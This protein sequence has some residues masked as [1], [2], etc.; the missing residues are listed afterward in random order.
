MKRYKIFISSVQSEFREERRDLKAF[1]LQDPIIK[2]FVE[3]VFIF[4]DIPAEQRPVNARPVAE[5]LRPEVVGG[6]TNW[7]VTGRNGVVNH[8]VIKSTFKLNKILHCILKNNDQAEGVLNGDFMSALGWNE[9]K[10]LKNQNGTYSPR[11]GCLKNYLVL[12]RRDYRIDCVF[13]DHGVLFIQ[14][15]RLE[16]EQ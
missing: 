11:R 2:D 3:S 12:L 16:V 15:Q 8:H 10:F 9:S 4:E 7:T 6:L 1:L 13:T 14:P 5:W